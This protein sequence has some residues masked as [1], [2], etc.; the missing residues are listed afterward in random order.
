M[1]VN[2]FTLG[3]VKIE[4]A[5]I[6]GLKSGTI[7]ITHNNESGQV[8]GETWDSK[9][10]LGSQWEASL[11]CDYDPADTVQSALRTDYVAG[12]AGLLQTTVA[13]YT[14]ASSASTFFSGSA[15]ITGVTL[16]RAVGAIDKISFTFAGNGQIA[17]T[18]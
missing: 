1:A 9:I 2:T 8:I 11:E 6:A 14:A 17:Y 18:A 16:T 15:I 3:Q 5:K 10:I 13:M 4:A 12:G 7:T